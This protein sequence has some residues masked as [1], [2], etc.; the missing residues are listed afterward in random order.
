MVQGFVVFEKSATEGCGQVSQRFRANAPCMLCDIA[1][2]L[3]KKF[4][5][6]LSAC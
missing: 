6:F 2:D 5:F 1:M 4:D 3:E